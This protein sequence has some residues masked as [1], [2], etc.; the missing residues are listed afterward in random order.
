VSENQVSKCNN[1]TWTEFDGPNDYTE[2]ECKHHCQG[3]DH[4][5][6]QERVRYSVSSVA[7]NSSCD[8][9]D[10]EQTRT[11]TDGVWGPGT[12]PGGWTGTF[13]EETCRVRKRDCA[14]PGGGAAILDGESLTRVRYKDAF[15]ATTCQAETQARLCTDGTLAASWTPNTFTML[16]CSPIPPKKSNIGSCRWVAD[17]TPR[18]VEWPGTIF[19]G[20]QIWC[21]TMPNSTFDAERGCPSE[22]AYATC[23]TDALGDHKFEYYY[24]NVS[25]S[26]CTLGDFTVL[27]N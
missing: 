20:P 11:C 2:T 5:S 12:L 10:E 25:S 7:S 17:S 4:G 13:T 3:G 16:A 9:V 1:G 19:V 26:V 22:N 24:V 18:C 8:S 23:E 21:A 27:D 15:S 6:T 14:R